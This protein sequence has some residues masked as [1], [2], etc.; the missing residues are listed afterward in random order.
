MKIS[1]CCYFSIQADGTTD[2]GN[3]E[4]E[5]FMTLYLDRHSTDGRVH[6]RNRFLTTRYLN[7][8]TAKG[9]Y[10]AFGRVLNYVSFEEYKNKLIGFTCD[11]TKVNI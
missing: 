9:L 4:N 7:C 8:G 3:T 11:G 1:K 2:A 5:L 10:E 6:V